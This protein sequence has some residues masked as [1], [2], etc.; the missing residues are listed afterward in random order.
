MRITP[1]AMARTTRK[2]LTTAA[3]AAAVTGLTMLSGGTAS[4]SSTTLLA[5]SCTQL[6][7]GRIGDDILLRG[8]SVRDLVKQGAKEA[9]TIAV[10][11]HLTIWPDHLAR[12]IAKEQLPVGSVPNAQGGTITG[13]ALGSAVRAA[14]KDSAG[15]GVLGETKE[16]TLSTIANKV[17]GNCGLPVAATNYTS[18]SSPRDDNPSSPSSPSSPSAP[19]QDGGTSA[20]PGTGALEGTG[21]ATV[22][23]RDY[24]DIPAVSPPSAG[25]GVPPDLRYPP[26]SGIP[27]QPSSPEF[28]ILGADSDDNGAR[29]GQGDDVRNAGNADAI[30][31]PP[32][33][34][35]VQLP[36]LLAVVA[37]AGVTAALVRTWV[38]RRT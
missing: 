6:V 19:G 36:M 10:V 32:S 33:Q 30:A 29:A 17:A 3:V 35:A 7:Q 27:G 21:G 34:T 15:I 24:G 14:L 28:G 22:P 12:E 5:D 25:I 11:H 26:S 1:T 9:Q 16:T 18:P 2:V 13:S 38:L 31:A 4:A 8:E 20:T 23:P 37:L